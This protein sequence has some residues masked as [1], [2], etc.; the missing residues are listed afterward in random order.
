MEGAGTNLWRH[1]W[2][3]E[4]DYHDVLARLPPASAIA[5]ERLLHQQA[6]SDERFYSH[7]HP[8]LYD[9]LKPPHRPTKRSPHPGQP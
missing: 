8:D 4:Y 6:R 1:P 7:L 9:E 5:F 3:R 2:L